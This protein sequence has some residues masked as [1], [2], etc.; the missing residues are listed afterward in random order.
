MSERR[1][2]LRLVGRGRGFGGGFEM[3]SDRIGCEK[4]KG[5]GDGGSFVRIRLRSVG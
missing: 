2:A 5:E 1:I 3:L 4:R